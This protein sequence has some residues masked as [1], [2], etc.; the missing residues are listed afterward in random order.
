MSVWGKR[1]SY[2]MVVFTVAFWI[3]LSTVAYLF[4][5]L[6]PPDDNELLAERPEAFMKVAK[7]QKIPWMDPSG[8][9]FRTAQRLDRPILLVLGTGFSQ[10]REK[11]DGLFEVPE[12]SEAVRQNFVPVRIDLERNPG[13]RGRFLPIARTA[14]G[15]LPYFQLLVLDY[16]GQVVTWF[17]AQNLRN[18]NESGLI[19]LLRTAQETYAARSYD[20]VEQEQKDEEFALEG[21]VNS[22][23]PDVDGYLQRLKST[24]SLATGGFNSSVELTMTPQDFQ[25]L[26]DAG[27]DDAL[28]ASLVPVIQSQAT[29]VLNG[30]FFF[31][32][33]DGD[34]RNTDYTK[35]ATIEADMTVLM[36]RLAVRDAYARYLAETSFDKL[37]AEVNSGAMP[38]YTDTDAGEANR[39]LVYSF[40]PNRLR[41]AKLTQKEWEWAMEVLNLDV[42][43]NPQAMVHVTNPQRFL[44]ESD[45]RERVFEKLRAMEPEGT[46]ESYGTDLLAQRAYVLGRLLRASRLLSPERREAATAA[47]VTVRDAMRVGINDVFGTRQ[48]EQVTPGNLSAYLAYGEAAYQEFEVTGDREVLN[49]GWQ[50]FSRGLFLYQKKRGVLSS[51]DMFGTQSVLKSMVPDV[52]DSETMSMVAQ[53]V[54]TM[55]HYSKTQGL[56]QAL[57]T[58]TDAQAM[59]GT[60]SGP[61]A[62]ANHGFSGLARAALALDAEKKSL[63]NGGAVERERGGASLNVPGS[64]GA[65]AP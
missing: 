37:L 56:N 13:W 42:S 39:S 59:L 47:F 54:M 44:D 22:G 34:W 61:M 7:E 38:T 46:V 33:Q 65:I 4:R 29:D 12:V 62:E 9:M 8:E 43:D 51:G 30:G 3:G 21:G 31:S 1:E 60:C 36:A 10:L 50:V 41:Q 19:G 17:T 55:V 58:L 63:T 28:K 24:I 5:P 57:S 18:Q 6:I 16:K 35:V 45:L 2:S 15:N 49:D 53:A 20:A 48:N 64:G 27:E 23:S 32:C 11:V 14:S 26:L 52:V 25:L 40:P